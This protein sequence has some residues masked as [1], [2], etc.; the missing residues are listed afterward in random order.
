MASA[1]SLIFELAADVAHLRQDMAKAN[2]TI[3]SSLKGI[4]SAVTGIAAMQ[5]AQYAMQFAKAFADGIKSAIDQA[6]ALGKLAQRIGTTTEALSALTYAGEFAGVSTDDLT[7]AFKGLNKALLEARDPASDS[8]AAFKAL[9]LNVQELQGMDPSAAFEKIADRVS[10]FADGAEKAAVMT[11][12]FGKQG[13]ALIPLMN[14]GAEGIA[15]A[16][17][18]AEKL[19]L[20]VSTQ[21]AQAMSDLNDNF[22]RLSKVSEGAFA[23]IA[24]QLTPALDTLV[25][26]IFA[27]SQEGSTW[28]EVLIGIGTA[29]SDLIIDVTQ[30]ASE[31]AIAWREL[32]GY[33]TAVK[34]FFAGDFKQAMQTTRDAFQKS[35][36]EEQALIEQMQR[37]KQLQRESA[38]SPI[39]LGRGSD[40]WD[41]KPVLK[42]TAAVDAN[43]KAA[44]K[45]KK[46]VDEYAQMLTSLQEE[47]RRTQANGDEMQMLLTDPKFAKFT[48]DQKQRLIDLKKGTLDLAAANDAAKKSEEELQKVRDDA[49]KAHIARIEGLRSLADAT[50]D[51]LDPTR[52]YVRTMTDLVAAQQA[53]FLST[54]QLAAAQ[55][56]QAKKMQDAIDKTN[57]MTEQIKSLQ[58]AV[59]GFGKKSSDALVDFMFS[60]KDASVSFSEMVTAMLK[61]IAKLLV[62]KNV[63]EPLVAGINSGMG[64]AGGWATAIASFFKGNRMAGGPVAP[65]GM[66]RVNE[67]PLRGE[68]FVPNAPGRVVTGGDAGGA[69]SIVINVNSDTG[70]TTTGG[71]GAKAIELAKRIAMIVRQVIATEKRTGGLLAP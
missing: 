2:D 66:Y 22:T 41:E 51:T 28:N 44:K 10:K 30:L 31:I 8:A 69:T 45:A 67:T 68:Y 36:Q 26:T 6:D 38:K 43:A 54:E 62:Y 63:F 55:E 32:Q 48:D 35:I 16:R 20:I 5:G 24:A 1:G 52:E 65:G 25:T 49:D 34:Q 61:D 14:G 15:H 17:E 37:A 13:Q 40:T 47:F 4:Q 21:T 64:G 60:T 7:A 23:V 59:E 53:G 29:V 56:I 11:Q 39:D 58:Q 71:D 9:G 12:L 33:G 70:A 3:V 46:D 57:P 42:F 50:L 19:G 27:A 18:E